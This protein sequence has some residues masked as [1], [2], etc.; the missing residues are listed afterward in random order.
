MQAQSAA[1]PKHFGFLGYFCQSVYSPLR[2]YCF[3]VFLPLWICGSKMF[4]PPLDIAV[5]ICFRLAFNCVAEDDLE[6]LNLQ[7]FATT[8][9]CSA[10]N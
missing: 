4:Y 5:L 2:F 9:L 8:T 10:G 7:A 1:G 6:H 3:Y